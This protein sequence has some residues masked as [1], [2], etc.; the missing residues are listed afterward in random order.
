MP[1]DLNKGFMIS[2]RCPPIRRRGLPI[3]RKGVPMG[4]QYREKTE[5]RKGTIGRRQLNSLWHKLIEIP[6]ILLVLTELFNACIRTGYNL[7]RLQQSMTVI[8]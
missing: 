6:V 2:R 4:Q 3:T 5:S 1:D 7:R 8:F